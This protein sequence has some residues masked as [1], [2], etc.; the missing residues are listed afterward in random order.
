MLKFPGATRHMIHFGTAIITRHVFILALE[1][2]LPSSPYYVLILSVM[3]AS[4]ACSKSL[5]NV[6]TSKEPW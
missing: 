6:L 4:Y 2:I 1:I 3:L 5:N